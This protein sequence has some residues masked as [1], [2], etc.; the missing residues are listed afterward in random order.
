M[1]ESLVR[2]FIPMGKPVLMTP[3]PGMGESLLR[4]FLP[5]WGKPMTP[6]GSRR[7][8]F[9]RIFMHVA[10]PCGCGPVATA[11]FAKEIESETNR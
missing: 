1:G 5:G 11:G 2:P 10:G 7:A 3:T 6:T 4:P 8:R 9:A